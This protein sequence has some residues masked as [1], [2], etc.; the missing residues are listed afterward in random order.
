MSVHKKLMAARVKLQA[1]EMKKSGL[2]KFAGYSYFELGDFIP[3]IQTIFN[4]IGLCGVVSFDSTHATL[5]ITD[6]EDGTQIVVTSPMAEANLKGAHPI[7]NLGAVESYQRRYLWMTAMEIVE[8]DVIDS[9]PA[10]E[11]KP[12]PKPEP[13]PE[14][15]PVKPPVKMQGGEGPWQLK[16]TTEPGADLG[17]WIGIVVDAARHGLAQAGSEKD[18]M[19]L[20]KINRVIFDKLK[21]LSAHDHANLMAD[22]KTK[23]DTLKGNV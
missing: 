2:N 14:P 9:A 20:F 18:V 17:D 21:E 4:E 12:A 22:F 13:K 7:Q 3:H 6:V 19:D 5:C 11:P 15:K 16:V 23:K 1:T 10:A 8:H